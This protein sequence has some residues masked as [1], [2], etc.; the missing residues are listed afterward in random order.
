MNEK[1]E[2]LSSGKEKDMTTM[3]RFSKLYSERS[4][5]ALLAER[6]LGFSVMHSSIDKQKRE[7]CVLDAVLQ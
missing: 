3:N 6:K 2:R 7:N 1:R 5:S 4:L